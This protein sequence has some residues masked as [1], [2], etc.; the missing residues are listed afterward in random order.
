MLITTNT[1][2][3][4]VNTMNGAVDTVIRAV[5]T[6]NGAVKAVNGAADTVIRAA[7]TMDGATIAE[8]GAVTAMNETVATTGNP[9]SYPH[10]MGTS[11]VQNIIRRPVAGA[12]L[13]AVMGLRGTV[14]HRPVTVATPRATMGLLPSMNQLDTGPH[15]TVAPLRRTTDHQQW[16]YG[17][18]SSALDREVTQTRH[19][20][21]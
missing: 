16:M 5:N 6:M 15:P 12:V 14:S 8:R 3:G 13:V 1:V 11:T 20:S 9:W 4:A 18:P 21:C 7:N 10:S 2:N 19:Q 17:S